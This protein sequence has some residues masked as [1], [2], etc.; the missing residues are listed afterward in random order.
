MP[1]HDAIG[2]SDNWS[3]SIADAT[4]V[5]PGQ[6]YYDKIHNLIMEHPILSALAEEKRVQAWM[7][8]TAFGSDTKASQMWEVASADFPGY[9]RIPIDLSS[10]ISGYNSSSI[11]DYSLSASTSATNNDKSLFGLCKMDF[12]ALEYIIKPVSDN[13]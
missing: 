2:N 3:L 5:P 6:D 8:Y 9:T 1:Y 7:N 11:F 4:K 12:V 10:T 13:S